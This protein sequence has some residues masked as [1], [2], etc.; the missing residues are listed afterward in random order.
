[1]YVHILNVLRNKPTSADKV[2][3]FRLCLSVKLLFFPK[4]VKASDYVFIFLLVT[5]IIH[6]LK[7]TYRFMPYDIILVKVCNTKP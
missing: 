2:R 4:T 3:Q 7:T 5:S 1:M 6:G